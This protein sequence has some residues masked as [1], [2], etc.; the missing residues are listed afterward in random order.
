[1]FLVLTSA[2]IIFDVTAI[3]PV[4]SCNNAVIADCKH[5][6]FASVQQICNDRFHLSADTGTVYEHLLQRNPLK[7][8]GRTQRRSREGDQSTV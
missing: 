8:F 3:G 5:I 6:P 2:E 1:M 4:I 7:P